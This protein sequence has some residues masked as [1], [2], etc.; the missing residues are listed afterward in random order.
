M[1]TMPVLNFLGDYQKYSVYMYLTDLSF[2]F[3]TGGSI[4][5]I[6]VIFSNSSKQKST[7]K[8]TI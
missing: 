3:K 6:N 7:Q 8:L 1:N 5:Y 2:V 4:L